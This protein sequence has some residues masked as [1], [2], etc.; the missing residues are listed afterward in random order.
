MTIA[1]V[2]VLLV[3]V[4]AA[5]VLLDRKDVRQREERRELMNRVQ[6]PDLVPVVA[7]TQRLEVHEPEPD[8]AHL[9]GVVQLAPDGESA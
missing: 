2:V 7:P 3:V 9:V 1:L 4:V 5:F 8:D 6:R